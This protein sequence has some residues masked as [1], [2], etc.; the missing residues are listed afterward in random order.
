MNISDVLIHINESLSVEAR[1]SLEDE[2]RQI[3]G[4]VAP[5][6]SPGKQ[7][8]LVVAFDPQRTNSAALLKKAQAAGYTAQL[9]GA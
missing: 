4:V 9:V 1:S 5:R 2:M 6:F 7:H 3:E 8:L